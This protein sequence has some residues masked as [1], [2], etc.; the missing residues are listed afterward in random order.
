MRDGIDHRADAGVEPEVAEV[1]EL[2]AFVDKIIGLANL[3]L[4]TEVRGETEKRGMPESVLSVCAGLLP[5][6]TL[7]RL[8]LE[9]FLFSNYLN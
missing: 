6:N 5:S 8:S 2:D 9:C 7:E 4:D 1:P 3:S